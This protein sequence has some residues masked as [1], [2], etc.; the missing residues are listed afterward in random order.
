[1]TA[2]LLTSLA[3]VGIGTSSPTTILAV[4]P[5]TNTGSVG[6]SFTVDIN[7]YDVTDLYAYNVRITF[8]KDVITVADVARGP[9]FE[10]SGYWTN[11]QIWEI[12][13]PG[14]PYGVINNTEGFLIVGDTFPPTLPPTGVTGSGTLFSITF[15]IDAEGVSP[16][17]FD[18]TKLSTIIWENY[19]YVG[20]KVSIDHE[21]NDGFFDNRV[22]NALPV[23]VFTAP[24]SGVVGIPLTFTSTSSDDGWLISEEWDF[25]DGENATGTVVDHAFAS[26]GIYTVTL[27]VTD[28]DLATADATMDID[29]AI[30]MEG[31][32]MPDLIGW[33]AKPDHPDL[34]EASGDRHL[35]ILGRVGNPA[36]E[37]YEVYVEFKLYSKDEVKLLGSLCTDIYP[38]APGEIVTL[39]ADFDSANNQWRAFSGGYWVIYGYYHWRMHKY[40]G[41]ASCYSRP[42]STAEWTKGYVVKYISFHVKEVRHDIGILDMSTS[43]TMVSPGDLVDVCVN[44]TN[45]GAMT[46]TFVVPITYDGETLAEPEVTLE[47]GES[48]L[49]TTTWD[50]TGIEPAVYIVKATL[51]LLTY[52][53][54]ATDQGAYCVVY[55]VEP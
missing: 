31:G 47:P 9:F 4:D 23:A 40:I 30:W 6:G 25:G 34:D 50:T 44:V 3:I 2:M 36:E 16:I 33:Y 46:E 45:E 35:D 19:P 8:D 14:E 1:M 12:F 52:E 24:L 13:H 10:K 11:W 51:P 22:E 38:I 27:T 37:E 43:E 21:A 20:T 15:D 48:Q 41:F 29:I 5:P 32:W 55:V 17:G 28:N 49:L 39:S 42:N 7:V 18:E 53:R 26:A 54:D